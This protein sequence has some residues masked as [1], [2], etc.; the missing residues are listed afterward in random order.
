[1]FETAILDVAIGLVFIYLLLSL[2]CS[3]FQEAAAA[4]F[5][6]RS[7]FLRGGIKTLLEIEDTP[8]SH[9]ETKGLDK[10]VLEHPLIKGLGSNPHPIFLP[11]YS[12]MPFQIS[13][14]AEATTKSPL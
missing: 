12:F 8:D 2:M 4:N 9:N 1:M 5:N 7:K 14:E 11:K 6:R 3:A 10:E 13:F